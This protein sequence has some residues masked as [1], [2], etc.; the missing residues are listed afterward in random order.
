MKF[1]VFR[2]PEPAI[3]LV[4]AIFLGWLLLLSG[5]AAA[6]AVSRGLPLHEVMTIYVTP[7]ADNLRALFSRVSKRGAP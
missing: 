3:D 7:T 4:R 1:G 5:S 2:R 6:Q